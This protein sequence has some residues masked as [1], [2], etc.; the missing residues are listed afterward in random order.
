MT[1]TS[2]SPFKFMISDESVTVYHEGRP[3]VVKRGSPQYKNL[4]D[5]LHEERWDDVPG[6]LT[7][8]KTIETW[9]NDKFEVKD[10]CVTYMGQEIPEDIMTRMLAMVTN[11][12]NPTIL[13]NFWERLSKNP[14]YR[15]VQQ[16]YGFLKHS[17]IPLTPEGKILTYKAVRKDLAPRS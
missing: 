7:V 10:N 12:E 9:S 13:F 2:K 4:T 3:W 17:N 8:T 11:G 1:T 16:L 14:S 5:A 6:H 15:S